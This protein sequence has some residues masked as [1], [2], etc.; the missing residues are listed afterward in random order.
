MKH[1]F[2][3]A[4]LLLILA[5]CGGDQSAQQVVPQSAGVLTASWGDARDTVMAKLA[6]EGLQLADDSAALAYTGGSYE[7]YAVDRWVLSFEEAGQL[8]SAT[9]TFAP[10]STLASALEMRLTEKFGQPTGP[11][12][13]S[14][15]ATENVRGTT[16][17]LAVS[18]GGP[19]VLTLEGTAGQQQVETPVVE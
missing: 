3:P 14:I 4:L 17:S 9:I 16:L 5:G 11:M 10:D 12:T 19:V 8:R 2:V 1:M 15:T 13:W 7:G 6:A 18:D